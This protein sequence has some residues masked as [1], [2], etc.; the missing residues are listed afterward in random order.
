MKDDAVSFKDFAWEGEADVRYIRYQA[1]ADTTYPGIQ[2]V[3][4]IIVR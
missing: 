3:D 4:E 2:F 1:I